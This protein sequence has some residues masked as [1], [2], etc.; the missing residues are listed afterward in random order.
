MPW[1]QEVIFPATCLVGQ[2]MKNGRV[3]SRVSLYKTDVTID[4]ICVTGKGN[5]WLATQT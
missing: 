3:V 2:R 1:D 4:V 5:R